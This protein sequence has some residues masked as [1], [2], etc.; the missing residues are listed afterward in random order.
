MVSDHPGSLVNMVNTLKE[1][2][3]GE[4]ESRTFLDKMRSFNEEFYDF[5]EVYKEKREKTQ[6]SLFV[7]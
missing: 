2:A 5:L 4:S 7:V 1:D 3:V 6:A